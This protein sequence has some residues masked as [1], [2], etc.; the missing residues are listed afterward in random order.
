MLFAVAALYLLLTDQVLNPE[1]SAYVIGQLGVPA[2][3]G[4]ILGI[5]TGLT[6]A[7]VAVWDII[8]GWRKAARA[9]RLAAVSHVEP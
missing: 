8:D 3:V 1:F 6:I 9:R 7:G 4:R 2:D 5:L